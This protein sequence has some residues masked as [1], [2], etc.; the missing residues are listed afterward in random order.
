M[1]SRASEGALIEARVAAMREIATARGLD[2]IVVTAESSIA[3]LTGFRANQ[4]GRL[5][6]A[7]IRADGGGALVVPL[8][9]IAAAT[10]A[11]TALDRVVYPPGSDGVCELVGAM[12]RVR[13]IGIEDS[14]FTMRRRAGLRGAGLQVE[15]VG[16]A[17]M[18]ARAIKDQH[19]LDRTREACRFVE[20]ALTMVF[21]TLAVGTSE[22][23]ATAAAHAWLI[24]R[25]A[26]ATHCSVLFGAAAARPSGHP[27]ERGLQP[28]DI[29]CADFAARLDG[30]WADVTRCAT[31]G[32]P[33]AW[34]AAAWPVVHESLD[35][36]IAVCREGRTTGD[37]DAAARAVLD[38]APE[39]GSCPH[40]AGHG[41][42][43][44]LNEWP[45]LVPGAAA[46]L[47]AGMVLTVEP[48]LY[49][50]GIGGLR[51][52]DDIVVTDDAAQRL[53]HLPLE[54]RE[55]GA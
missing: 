37:V 53:T 40:G 44:D 31:A 46:P 13:S 30:Y 54:L 22:R 33:S 12:P 43:V 3:Y 47:R 48:G 16:D 4:L 26:G 42:G 18:A 28:G 35:A 17:V 21:D 45:A 11:P 19:E 41:V 23:A 1:M 7:C 34:A 50:P 36:A 49:A 32:P 38:T 8:Q 52:E 10:A 55:V 27:G 15:P 14:H 20:E 25:G 29:V 24:E 51:L 9:H 2:A 39:L 6:A 5:A